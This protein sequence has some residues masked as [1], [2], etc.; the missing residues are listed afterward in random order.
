MLALHARRPYAC[1]TAQGGDYV[2]RRATVRGVRI[3]RRFGDGTGC[4][5]VPGLRRQHH[6]HRARKRFYGT[7]RD[8]DDSRLHVVC[9][10]LSVMGRAHHC[11]IGA[12][13]RIAVVSRRPQYA[14]IVAA[15]HARRER[16]AGHGGSGSSALHLLGVAAERGG[17]GRGWQPHR[18][19]VDI[20]RLRVDRRNRRAMGSHHGGDQWQRQRH[21]A[22]DD[23]REHRS[24]THLARSCGRSRC[25]H[26]AGRCGNGATVARARP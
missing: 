10:V 25:H 26:L 7:T 8:L 3:H 23:R 1:S 22:V 9:I 24:G 13:E 15:R 17:H 5:Q 11:D 14:T 6:H 19:G 16:L 20:D 12:G 2:C 18:V 4:S 21:G